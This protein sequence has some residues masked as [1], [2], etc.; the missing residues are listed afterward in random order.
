[1]AW[2]SKALGF[3]GRA[4]K[5]RP[6]AG[7]AMSTATTAGIGAV[8]GG[9]YGAMSGDT[10]IMGGAFMGALGGAGI[11]SAMKYGGA[12]MQKLGGAM[13][14][15]GMSKAYMNNMSRS[16]MAT[17]GSYLGMYGKKMGGAAS[18]ITPSNAAGA[19]TSAFTGA[20]RWAGSK[21]W[22][23]VK[24]VAQT[25]AVYAG[26]GAAAGAAGWLGADIANYGAG[27]KG[28]Q[29][30]SFMS[31]VG[32]GAAIGFAG[33][34]GMKGVGGVAKGVNAFGS[35]KFMGSRHMQRFQGGVGKVAGLVSG[36]QHSKV[37]KGAI[38][39]AAM[40]SGIK[41]TQPVNR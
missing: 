23:G 20:A 32:T 28:V 31:A 24:S 29:P 36:V 41:M 34:W 1:M 3:A 40:S 10:S 11:P 8:A 30:T 14:D 22:G 33:G 13:Y 38:G 12:G 4:G 35:S 9:A 25:S 15:S 18:M 6:P 26:G 19:A 39:V 5:Y 17:A 16:R 7:M 27:W 37:M 2:Y 21:G